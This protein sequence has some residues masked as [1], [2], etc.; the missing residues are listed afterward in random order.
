MGRSIPSSRENV[1]LMINDLKKFE[2][3]MKNEDI[4]KFRE[5]LLLG[6]KH[7]VEIGHNGTYIDLL[8][9]I[10]LEIYKKMEDDNQ[11]TWF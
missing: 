2:I 11:R 1:K 6:E 8:L 3:Y 9:M 4:I 10:L 7:A 5:M